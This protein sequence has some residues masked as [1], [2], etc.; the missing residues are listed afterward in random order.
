MNI[1]IV[2]DGKVGHSLSEQLCSEEHEVTII[3]SNPRILTVTADVLDVNVVSGN[4]ASMEVQKQAGVPSSDLLIAAT[5]SDEMNMVCC[6]V[7]KKLGADHT[8]ARIRNPEYQDQMRM[9]ENELNLS[10]SINPELATAAEISRLIRFPAALRMDTF[11][12][13]RVELIE[14]KIREGSPIIGRC[15]KDMPKI[16]DAKVLICAVDRQDEVTIPNGDFRLELGDKIHITGD[17]KEIQKFL[18]SIGKIEQKIKSVML[19]GGGK[20]SIYLA[21]MLEQMNI[22][23]TVIEINE[24]KCRQLC[25]RLP[26]V[27]I[28]H[29][30]GTDQEV[31]ESAGLSNMGAFVA[32]T[33]I[34]EEN[35]VTSMYA[36]DENV[37][38]VITKINRMNYMGILHKMGI[39]SVV[40]PKVIT[41]NQ[42]VRYVRAMQNTMGSAVQTLYR[43]V[44]DK[45]EALEF[46]ADA[47]TKFLGRTLM[48]VPI[49]KNLLIA[50]IVRGGRIII[51]G[52]RDSIHKGDSI[53]VVTAN[54]GLQDIND[55]FD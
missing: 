10:L 27:T 41:A 31:L 43:I 26:N 53:I 24:E 32:L 6:M 29:G 34:D 46:K 1:V 23:V 21:K 15:L 7:A 50:T 30:D 5:S 35:M 20:I 51:P 47:N 49:Q 54:K 19:L 13:G 36:V 25:E 40:S 14:F 11:V 42:I 3:D 12:R 48:E 18:R 38:K 2:G 4:G 8:I 37:Q 9:L 52:G 45:A 39:D 17:I 22:Q 16:S 28:I 55:I 33:D 44:N